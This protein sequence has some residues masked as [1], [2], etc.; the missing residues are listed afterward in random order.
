M[1][2]VPCRAT[3]TPK[4]NVQIMPSFWCWSCEQVVFGGHEYAYHSRNRCSID[5][6]LHSWIDS[7]VYEIS[8]RKDRSKRAEAP[9]TPFIHIKPNIT[10]NYDFSTK[11]R[12]CLDHALG[13]QA[14]FNRHFVSSFDTAP[15]VW[16]SERKVTDCVIGWF[17]S[18]QR[19]NKCGS[20]C[21]QR[22]YWPMNVCRGVASKDAI[23]AFIEVYF[24]S[25]RIGWPGATGHRSNLKD[26]QAFLTIHLVLPT[27][28][29]KL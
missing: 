29:C 9:R 19:P 4:T 8:R 23:I 15:P 1:W 28:E 21:H 24:N 7:F 5:L 6:H 17:G 12:L 16:Q 26:C 18:Y 27:P 2:T 20:N 10:G 14:I 11:L 25:L 13:P 3:T 22:I